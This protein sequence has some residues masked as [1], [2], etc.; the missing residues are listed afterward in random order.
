[1]A[2]TRCE[3]LDRHT[4]TRI[5]REYVT[6]NLT[7]VVREECDEAVNLGL[8]TRNEVVDL[9]RREVAAWEFSTPHNQEADHEAK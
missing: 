2:M 7:R 5:Q 1:M 9:V 3:E 4:A 6:A 8:L